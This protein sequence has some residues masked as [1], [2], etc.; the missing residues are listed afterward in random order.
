V[1]S[2]V[3]SGIDVMDSTV[4]KVCWSYFYAVVEF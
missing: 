2:F 3:F 1:M 4:F